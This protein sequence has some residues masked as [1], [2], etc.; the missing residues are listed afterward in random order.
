MNFRTNTQNKASQRILSLHVYN[1]CLVD[2]YRLKNLRIF[3]CSS[4]AGLITVR[5]GLS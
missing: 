1:N 3:I 2:I 5:L 4:L